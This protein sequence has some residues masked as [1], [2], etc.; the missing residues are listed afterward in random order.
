MRNKFI[1]TLSFALIVLSLIATPSRTQAQ[2][3]S[4]I[5]TDTRILYH[6]GPVMQGSPRLY[7][8]WYGN[9]SGD[10]VTPTILSHFASAL[11]SS[12]YFLINTTYPDSSGGTPSG[13]LVYAGSVSD[14]YSQGPSLTV[15]NIQQIV[16]DQIT[17]GALPLDT[18][19]I[20]VVIASSDVTDIQPDGSTFCTPG[21]SPHHGVGLYDGAYFKYAFLGAA[22]RCPTSA[23]PQFV[24]ANGTLLPTPNDSFAA[25][26]MVSTFGR[27]INATVTNP[28]GYSGWFDRY[29][30]QN[31]DKC[32]GKFGTTYT[33]PNGARANMR[34][35]GRDFLVQQNWINDRK[36]RC[37]L[38]IAD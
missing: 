34:L 10:G 17:S 22:N 21:A 5:K 33:T 27:L 30:L 38:S 36:G 28:M 23:G 25:D 29:G 20:Y 1:H 24:G 31:S 2:R 14:V 37:T 7:L 15:E 13:G 35:A 9:W 11:G 26:A 6:N 4:G 32:V 3:G 18:P 16:S 12:P 19:G 8:I